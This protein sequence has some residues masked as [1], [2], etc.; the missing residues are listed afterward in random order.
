MDFWRRAL[1]TS[2]LSLRMDK[3]LLQTD[4][5]IIGSGA[6]G[7]AFADVILTETDANLII[8]DKHHLP[9]GH[10]N[11]AYSFVTLH[12][13]SAFYGVSS[14][15]LSSGQKD[16]VGLNQGLHELATGAEV[17]SYFDQV[18]RQQFLPT[19]RVQY[20]PMCEYTG[21]GAFRS[22][23]SG[24]S[25]QVTVNRK[26][27][28]ATY[29]N[30]SVPS[31]HTPKFSVA[32]GAQLR[33]LNDLPKITKPRSAYVVVGGGKTGIDACLWLLENNV[34]PDKIRWIM[35]RDAWLMDRRNT[36]PTQ[37]FFKDTMGAQAAQM[38]SIA[39]ASSIKDLFDR[40]EASG[41]LLR[42]DESVRPKM[43]H[44]ATISK[45]E[46]KQLRRIKN[47]VRLGHVQRIEENQIILD[48]GSISTDPNCLHIDCSARAV[49][50]RDIVPVFSDGEI[51]IQTVRTI[52]PVFSAA[53]IAHV[54]VAYLDEKQKNEL[55]GV[56]PLPNHDTDWLKVT[57]ALMLNQQIWSKDPALRQWLLENRL[58]GFSRMVA[59]VA[60]NDTESLGILKRLRDN[61]MPAMG[62][63]QRFISELS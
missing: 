12:Q 55:C 3:K 39:N 25:F 57:A 49:E 43:Y 24:E 22:L 51:T 40:L 41:V 37:E 42:I 10:W 58:D 54:E 2:C 1:I 35:P 27:V 34:E 26:T 45:A 61:A 44:G 33:P 6:V 63:L 48:Q 60:E 62:K 32:P 46:L 30:T 15:E 4:Y 16:Q 21:E 52:Q 28:D 8:V 18:M 9:G 59:N 14:R 17:S 13:P 20:F 50:L 56:V 31:T 11:D 7:M 36:Q 19:G 38:E 23:L 47:I 53:F 5:L 29:F